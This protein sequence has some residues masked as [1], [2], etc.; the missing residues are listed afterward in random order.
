MNLNCRLAQVIAVSG[1]L[2]GSYTS[3]T[4][5]ELFL[6]PRVGFSTSTGE[7][8]DFFVGNGAVFGGRIFVSL[9]DRFYLGGGGA[10]SVFGGQSSLGVDLTDGSV[11]FY[12]DGGGLLYI[13]KKQDYAFRPYVAGFGGWGL[14]AWSYSTAAEQ[15]L[16]VD[17]DSNGFLFL[18][19]EAGLN[20]G[21]NESIAV[22]IGARYL[23]TRYGDETRENFQWDLSGG[24]FFEV[25][26]SL[27]FSL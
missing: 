27:D 4:A 7:V 2:L 18:V 17:S 8:S 12:F 21:V 11:Q 5:D 10:F 24:D 13:L 15:E 16:G 3:S 23:I 22:D 14:L 26:L 9:T 25:F 20:I 1:A 6:Q 19:P